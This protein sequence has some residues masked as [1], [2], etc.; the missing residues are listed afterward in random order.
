MGLSRFVTAGTFGAFQVRD[1]RHEKIKFSMTPLIR[2]IATDIDG[3]LLDSRQ[4]LPDRN[5]DALAAA[6]AAGIEVVLVTGRR[7]PFAM[8]IAQQL[9]FDHTLITCNGAVIRTRAGYTH[10]RR[11]LP[12]PT[13]AQVLAWTMPWR[14]Y[15]MLA[16]DEDVESQI[17]M[18]SLDKRTPLFLAWY[19]RIKKHVRF[20]RLEDGLQD[21]ASD[22][23][24]V[25]FSGPIAPLRE[26]E[27]SL[28]ASPFRGD[29]VITKTFYDDK[30]L[31]IMDLIHPECSKG[32]A[33]AFWAKSC[34]I[35][36]EQVMAVG[37]N[38]NDRDMLEFAGLSIVMGNA[39]A[40]LLEACT[41]K[42]WHV[43]LEHDAAGLAVAVE[44]WALAKSSSS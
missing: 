8:P 11:L 19:E 33:L 27:A 42:G 44:K 3:T 36:R 30:D 20:A 43:T 28:L 15:T 25:M 31:G 12:R 41:N 34:G 6:N 5:R 26:I 35:P 1:K 39:V 29:F 14:D 23:L 4:R 16:Y 37:D 22:P 32:A 9:P 17:V 40:T 2:M 18:E 10:F 21:Q 7:Y 24:Q 38:H 13:A